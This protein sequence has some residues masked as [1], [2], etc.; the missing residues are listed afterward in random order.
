MPRALDVTGMKFGTLTAIS[1]RQIRLPNGRT[2]IMWLC[3]CDCGGSTE[4][5][6]TNLRTGH[7]K[8]CGCR[9]LMPIQKH[10]HARRG[11]RH[12]LY[13]VWVGMKRRCSN[14]NDGKW[15]SYGGRGIS[16]C[17][18]WKNDFEAFLADMGPR[19]SPQHSIDRIDNDGNY[20]PGNCRWAT[21]TD[22]AGNRRRRRRGYKRTPKA[23]GRNGR[24][25]HS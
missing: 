19:P 20:E 6:S 24:S 23:H 2:T 9:A 1:Q 11:R 15:S 21:A 12:E 7:T 13:D 14:Q 18:R 17:E 25:A 10:G 8:T 16:V 5:T 4:V 3:A 22:Q